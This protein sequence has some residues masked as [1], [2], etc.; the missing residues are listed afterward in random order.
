M[1]VGPDLTYS[2]SNDHFVAKINAAGTDLDY[3]GYIGGAQMEDT[4]GA[5]AVD[6]AGCAYVTGRTY[7]TEATFP[8]TVGPDLT[9]SGGD[10]EAY[11]AKVNPAGTAL[12]YC[13]YIGGSGADD[14]S[15]I[16][17]DS[18][19]NAFVVGSTKST[20]ATFPVLIG[21]DL[22]YNG[23]W[24]AFVAKANAS[25]TALDFCGYNGPRLLRLYRRVER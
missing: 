13:G 18:A 7:S 5:I 24:D 11:V 14:G 20:E 21:P 23:E 9:Y 17:V 2:G 15:G 6:S 12:D 1:T 19:G 22:S 4:G 3:C 25:G 16:A 8:V 10:G